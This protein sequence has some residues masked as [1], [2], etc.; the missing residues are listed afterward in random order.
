LQSPKPL[1]ANPPAIIAWVIDSTST[2][3]RAKYEI[4]YTRKWPT[5][6]DCQT[7]Q[8]NSKLAQTSLFGCYNCDDKE[9][10]RAGEPAAGL[11]VVCGHRRLIVARMRPAVCTRAIIRESG[12]Q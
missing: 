7:V 9:K 2:A 4:V 8:L 11:F 5:L 10:P 12:A 1:R 3:I 6:P